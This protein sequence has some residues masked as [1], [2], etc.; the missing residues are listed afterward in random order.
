MEQLALL[1]STAETWADIDPSWPAEPIRRYIPGTDSGT[2]DYFVEVVYD[3]DQE[4][5]LNAS[6]LNMNEDDNI[7]VQGVLGSPYA[8][9]FFGFA[10]YV[11]NQCQMRAISLGGVAPNADTA[12]SGD[13]PLSRPLFLYSDAAIMKS[14]PQ[15]AAFIKFFLDFVNEEIDSVGYFPASDAALEEARQKWETAIQ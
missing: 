3:E 9:G 7:L 5:I 13:Y 2:F 8:V 12:E 15:V 11:E 4:P 10:Y 6:N 14:K 1:F